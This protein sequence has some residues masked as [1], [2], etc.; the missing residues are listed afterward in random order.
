VR[1]WWRPWRCFSGA[2]RSSLLRAGLALAGLALAFEALLHLASRQRASLTFDLG[3]STGGY[4]AGFTDSEERPPVTFRWTRE[5]AALALPLHAGGPEGESARLTLRYA[6]FIREPANVRVFLDGRPALSFRARSGRFRTQT[7]ALEIPRGPLRMELL[8]EGPDPQ[9][10]GLAVDWL[11]I[12]QV[13]WRLPLSLYQPRLLILG[14]FLVAGAAGFGVR[15]RLLAAGALAIPAAI[16]AGNDPFGF[17]HVSMRLALPA[18]GL[19]LVV[20]AL[21]RGRAGGRSVTLIF[22]AGYLIKGAGL[23]YPTYFYPDVR[24]HARYVLAFTRAEGNLEERGRAAQIEV[25]TAYPRMVAGKA[26]AFPYSPVFFIPFGW[27]SPERSGIED[28]L[29]HVALAAGAAEV[30]VVYWLSL[31]AGARGVVAA[32]LAAFLPAMYSRLLLA[33]WPTIA[34]HLL[35]SLSLAAALMLAKEPTRPSRLLSFAG[36]T[37]A[38]LLT[39][40]S[41]L[42]NLGAFIGCASLFCFRLAGRLLAVGAVAAAVTVCWLYGDFTALFFREIVPA[43]RAG[44]TVGPV[45]EPEMAEGLLAALARIPLF[46]G[47]AY[48]ALAVAGLVPLRRSAPPPIFRLL[49]A[50]GL[51]FFLLVVLRGVSGGLFKDL[52]EILFV[53]PLIALG[54]GA[55]L[56]TLLARRGYR[57]LAA[58]LIILSFIAFGLE[59]YRSYFLAHASL[60]GL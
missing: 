4:L 14:V 26:Y 29:K 6:R 31:L 23:F 25:N 40:I 33:M 49:L 53:G 54:A 58:W 34:G 7:F 59:R 18:I 30:V 43:L 21:L 11:R 3:P 44:T 41:S 1:K 28:G 48:P 24:N 39:Y 42:F 9:K 13:R 46:Y 32:L 38:S 47:Y 37:L 15:A 60:A 35:D 36:A 45:G 17:A 2:S 27:L 55:T 57:A 16:W 51:A 19:G 8:T 52:K 22:L 20:A 12:E 5:R 56:E 10:L 50:Y